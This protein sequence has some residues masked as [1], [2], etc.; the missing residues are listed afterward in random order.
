MKLLP[1]IGLTVAAIFV[2]SK[3]TTV[4]AASRVNFIISGVTLD[5]IGITPVLRIVL[6]AQNPTSSSFLISAVTANVSLN[7]QPIG[8]I[9][10][11][12]VDGSTYTPVQVMPLSA[13]P[14]PIVAMI[15]L[16]GLVSDITDIMTGA[17]GLHAIFHI[18]GTANVE[19]FLVPL[20]IKYTAL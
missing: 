4:S 1:A 19:G 18:Q 20:D 12:T 2:A 6:Q 8:N 5:N 9:T 14:V 13:T 7:D 3:L 15:G 17:A 16:G 11:P 10:G